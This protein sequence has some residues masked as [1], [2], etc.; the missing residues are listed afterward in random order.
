MSAM[1]SDITLQKLDEL[2]APNGIRSDMHAID[3]RVKM[4]LIME[5]KASMS[6][7]N[8][9]STSNFIRSIAVSG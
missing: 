2:V 8:A 1:G 4:V 5:S 3:P 6:R 9:E 7:R